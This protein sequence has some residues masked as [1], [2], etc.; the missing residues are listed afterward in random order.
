MTHLNVSGT[1]SI[2]RLRD[3]EEWPD[4]PVSTENEAMS[5]FSDTYYDSSITN[6][7]EECGHPH[8]GI[9][10]KNMTPNGTYIIRKGRR[11]ERRVLECVM[12]PPEIIKYDQQLR[13]G[14][15][16]RCSSTFDNI[17]SLLKEGLL[18]GLDEPPPDF[19]PPTPPA[20]VRVVSLPSL[21]SEDSNHH[22]FFNDLRHHSREDAANHSKTDVCRLSRP[23]ELAVTMEEE[24]DTPYC[25][26]L[27]DKD[28][29]ES[30]VNEEERR[31]I[32]QLE[33]QQLSTS[34]E[35]LSMTDRLLS[36]EYLLKKIITDGE[37]ISHLKDTSN[38]CR[39][40][41]NDQHP[42]NRNSHSSCVDEPEKTA[43]RNSQ[44][45]KRSRGRQKKKQAATQELDAQWST[46]S[47]INADVHTVPVVLMDELTGASSA[48]S[49]SVAVDMLR[50][51]FP[52][53]PPSPVEEDDE[54][55]EILKSSPAKTP[56]E[57]ADTLPEPFYRSL[58]PPGSDPCGTR[59]L[60]RPCPPEPPPHLETISSLKTRSMDAGFNRGSHNHNGSS[61]REVSITV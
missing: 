29:T 46:A 19:S 21:A 49:G 60:N 14:D 33:K 7:N 25:F 59:F 12:Q 43:T 18:E 36:Q 24:E 22:E 47:E 54:Y 17:K 48:D 15:L 3:H 31:L 37:S 32:E 42:H 52:P 20:L 61:R 8:P 16:K 11:K 10:G 28:M 38:Y 39:D 13:F 44:G 35:S 50:H 27:D 6:D 34:S 30:D 51:E 23:H 53:L 9:S 45:R 1:G 58:E 57:Q 26:S 55:S 41:E 4:P 40:S 5:P 56:E 2:H